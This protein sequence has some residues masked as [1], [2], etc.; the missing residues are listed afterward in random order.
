MEITITKI[1]STDI[2]FM[3]GVVVA[4]IGV[5]ATIISVI[6]A[7]NALYRKNRLLVGYL[8]SV[9]RDCMQNGAASKFVK[10]SFCPCLT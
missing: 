1:T 10:V 3:V 7:M 9:C 6:F 8:E 4:A 2:I 5:I